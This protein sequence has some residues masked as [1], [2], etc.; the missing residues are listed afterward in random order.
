M[1]DVV[2]ALISPAEVVEDCVASSV[3][4]S[5]SRV[6]VAALVVTVSTPDSAATVEDALTSSPEDKESS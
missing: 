3:E 5:A 1:V 6:A 2:V 4:S